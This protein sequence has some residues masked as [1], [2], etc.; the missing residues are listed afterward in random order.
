[1]FKEVVGIVEDDHGEVGGIAE[2]AGHLKAS[3]GEAECTAADAPR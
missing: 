3:S 2:V 1:M